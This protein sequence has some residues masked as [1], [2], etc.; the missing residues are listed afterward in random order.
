MLGTVRQRRLPA[1]TKVEQ[2]IARILPPG[3]EDLAGADAR[4][5]GVCLIGEHTVAGVRIARSSKRRGK[6]KVQDEVQQALNNAQ[7]AV[8]NAQD[9]QN[10]AQDA[11]NNAQDAVDNAVD[12]YNRAQ[13]G[14]GGRHEHR[15]VEFAELA[16]RLRNGTISPNSTARELLSIRKGLLSR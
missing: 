1:P 11:L 13:G 5:Y 2:D 10:R 4:D 9:A 8:N 3:K 12:A 14:R 15:A 16:L 6:R 7:A